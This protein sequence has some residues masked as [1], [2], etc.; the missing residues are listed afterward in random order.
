MVGNEPLNKQ[1]MEI[2]HFVKTEEIA[3]KINDLFETERAILVKLFPDAAIEHI[4]GTS[5]S[6][7]ISKGDLD[8]NV[9]IKPEAF[10]LESESIGIQ[11][12]LSNS[13]PAHLVG[14]EPLGLKISN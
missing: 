14:I 11:R 13:L 5:I 6:G 8:I 9:R 12:G 4:G 10:D 2:V 1:S 7:A 3:E